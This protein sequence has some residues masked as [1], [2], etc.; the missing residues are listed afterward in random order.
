MPGCAVL[1]CK[2]RSRCLFEKE[3][4]TFFYFPKDTYLKQKWLESCGRKPGDK[5][6][7]AARICSIHF[8]SDC[9]EDKLTKPSRSNVKPRMIRRLIQGS[10]PTLFLN[11][12]KRR[13]KKIYNYWTLS[14]NGGQ[15]IEGREENSQNPPIDQL[16]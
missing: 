5:K 3:G 1:N 8:T 2:S 6:L 10:I 15:E 9:F 13:Q 7:I 16:M 12:E 14:A 11:L 4:I